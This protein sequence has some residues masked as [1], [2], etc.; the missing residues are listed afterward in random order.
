MENSGFDFGR[1]P[2]RSM[3]MG[4]AGLVLTLISC[5]IG[6]LFS[7]LGL[8]I[9]A[10]CPQ[11]I[12]IVLGVLGLVWGRAGIKQ[13]QMGDLPEDLMGK[14]KIGYWTSLI[15]LVLYALMIVLFIV[16][17]LLAVVF[18]VGAGLLGTMGNGY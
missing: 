11:V 8:S 4:I 2:D 13:I 7:L 17:I 14:A 3:V 16:I 10:C 18:G 1:N 5:M 6:G 12:A 9:I 15:N